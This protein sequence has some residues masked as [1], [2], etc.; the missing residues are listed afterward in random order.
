[1]LHSTNILDIRDYG[2]IGDGE[3][4]N[5]DAFTAADDAAAGRK[6]LV[7]EGQFYIEKGLTLR[8][9]LLFRGTVKLPV[10]APFV[11][12]NNFDFTTYIDAFGEEEL[13]FKKAFQALLNSGDHDALDLG[14]AHH[15][16]ECPDRSSRS[17]F[18]AAGIC[19]AAGYSKRRV[20]CPAQYSMGKRYCHLTRNLLAI[21]SQKAAQSQ[22]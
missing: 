22:Q 18:Y 4:P 10:S 14:G 1:M 3:T 8:S 21:R 6:L 11:L 12:Q 17:R 13:A 16:R 7:P 2:A 5:Y 15:R 20:I 19:G 9:K